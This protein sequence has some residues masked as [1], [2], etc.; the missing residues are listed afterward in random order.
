MSE[1]P[2]SLLD[3]FACA[4]K[5]ANSA[6]EKQWNMMRKQFPSIYNCTYEEY[7]AKIGGEENE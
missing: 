5:K 3:K 7:Q 2:K 1:L 4:A 6:N